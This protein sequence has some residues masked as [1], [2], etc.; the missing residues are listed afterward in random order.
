MSS[1]ARVPSWAT[2]RLLATCVLLCSIRLTLGQDFA[3]GVQRTPTFLWSPESY[4]K[5]GSE[6]QK[7]R[8]SYEV[9]LAESGA[10]AISGNPSQSSLDFL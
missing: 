10:E 2:S 7:S 4:V 1:M 8:V 6:G 9:R 3:G 5:A